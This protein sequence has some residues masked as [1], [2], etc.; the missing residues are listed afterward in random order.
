MSSNHDKQLDYNKTGKDLPASYSKVGFAL[1]GVGLV[2]VL[3]SFAVDSLR[4]SFNSVL[5]FTL[6]LS[7]GVGSLF[8]VSLEYIAGAVWSTPFRRISENLSVLTLVAPILAI[9]IVLNMHS[10]YHWTHLEVVAT[11]EL[12][13]FKQPYLNES[14]FYVRSAAFFVIMGLFYYV[15]ISGSDKQDKTGDQSITKRNIIFSAPFMFIFA[16]LISIMAIDY[17]MS[18]EPHWFSTIFGVYYF[19][20][21]F[22]SA[23]ATLTLFVLY[24][25]DKNLLPAAINKNHLYNLGALMFAFTAF[26]TYI[27]FSQFVLIWYANLPEETLWFIPR[28]HNGWEYLSIGIIFVHFIIPFGLLIQRKAKMNPTRLKIAAFWILFAHIYDLYWLIMPT[29]S[30]IN[31]HENITDGNGPQFGWFELAFPIL[32]AGIVM[33]VF[34]IVSKNKPLI[35]IGDPKL[36]RGLDFH[37]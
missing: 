15:F 1:L 29:Y 24:L 31:N 23:I 36:Q 6:L 7:I 32:V 9:P 20:G 18:L 4:A 25:K 16:I 34:G 27:A 26:W 2:L 14:F 12:L 37:L 33:V 5:G 8:M 17:L 21:T 35:P 3:A 28:M 30:R 19:A 13:K 10:I 22:L 11:D